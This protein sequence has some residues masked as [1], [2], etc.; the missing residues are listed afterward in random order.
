M[1]HKK[2]CI[3]NSNW[4]MDSKYAIWLC[5]ALVK[6]KAY[7]SICNKEFNITNMGKIA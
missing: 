7:C 6:R 1:P 4:L 2:E 5:K 3:F